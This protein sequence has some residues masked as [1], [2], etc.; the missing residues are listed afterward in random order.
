[1]CVPVQVAGSGSRPGGRSSCFPQ[2]R[3]A[4]TGWRRPAC[5]PAHCPACR[6]CDAPAHGEA[7]A[8]AT[9][10]L[11]GPPAGCGRGRGRRNVLGHP[12]DLDSAG[13][14]WG[15]WRVTWSAPNPGGGGVHPEGSGK[16]GR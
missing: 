10:P 12:W 6:G 11:D 5:E 7:W 3:L 8:A 14:C 4:L 1:M 9:N 2:Q 16:E 15:G 13:G